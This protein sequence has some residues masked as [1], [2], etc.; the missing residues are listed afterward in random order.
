MNLR[1]E[2]E[3]SSDGL[4]DCCGDTTRTV[5]G[6][7]STPERTVAAYFVSW[8]LDAVSS[9]GASFDF[10]I[11]TWGDGTAHN[12]RAAVALEFRLIEGQPN[13]MVRDATG[14]PAASSDLV[15]RALRRAEVIDTPL[16]EQV[17][18]LVDAVWLQDPRI[19]EVTAA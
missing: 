15:A 7:I 13:F 16:A 17:F 14:R 18:N 3:S 11:G 9:H 5:N 1:V 2:P 4:C 8:T 10:I 6:F 12:D 19:A